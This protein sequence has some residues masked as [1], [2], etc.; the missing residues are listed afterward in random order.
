MDFYIDGR[1][2]GD[3]DDIFRKYNSAA[4]R[5]KREEVK[6]MFEWLKKKLQS[7]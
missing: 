5:E 7:L 2:P 3:L 1:Y 6:K 4:T